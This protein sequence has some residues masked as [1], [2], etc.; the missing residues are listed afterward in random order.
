M[1]DTVDFGE[2]GPNYIGVFA[3]AVLGCWSFLNCLFQDVELSSFLGLTSV[4]GRGGLYV[5]IPLR[6]R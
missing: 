3:Q 1:L 5:I 6:W 4:L 2:V